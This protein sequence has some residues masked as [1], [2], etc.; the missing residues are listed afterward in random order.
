MQYKKYQKLKA[1]QT[2]KQKFSDMTRE[3]RDGFR[4]QMIRD[5]RTGQAA[6][7]GVNSKSLN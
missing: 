1:M 7:C 4:P 6:F 5:I 3:Y 2:F